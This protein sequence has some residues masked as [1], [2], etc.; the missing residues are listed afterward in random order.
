ML[1]KLTKA[2]FS[3]ETEHGL[4]LI[5]F[6]APWCGYCKRQEPE[7]S[8]MDKVWI[9][10]VNADEEPELTSSFGINSFPT[11]LVFKDGKEKKR[12]SGYRKKEDLIMDLMRD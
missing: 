5:E 8:A 10:Q 9:G 2:D 12:F 1:K 4:K 11:F 7:L 6:Y 3:K